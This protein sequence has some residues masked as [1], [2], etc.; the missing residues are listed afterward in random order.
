MLGMSTR[1]TSFRER[2]YA[3]AAKIP[4]GKVATYGQIARLAGAPN[5]ARAVGGYMARNQDTQQCPC[6]RV[7]GARG[8]LVGYAYGGLEIKRKKLFD[9]GVSFSGARVNLEKS[10]WRK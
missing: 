3:A 4:R 7:V 2:V 6:H 9:E 8:A 1:A 10:G 5:A